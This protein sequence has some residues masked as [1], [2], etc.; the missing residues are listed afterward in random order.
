MVGAQPY[1]ALLGERDLEDKEHHQGDGQDVEPSQA[2]WRSTDTV[3]RIHARR[4]VR[5]NHGPDGKRE[6]DDR[7]D[8]EDAPVDLGA[9]DTRRVPPGPLLSS[10][11]VTGGRNS[12]RRGPRECSGTP[13]SAA[14]HHRFGALIPGALLLLL[15]GHVVLPCSVDA[16]APYARQRI[17]EHLI[18]PKEPRPADLCIWLPS[19]PHRRLDARGSG[20][21]GTVTL[22]STGFPVDVGPRFFE[23]RR[24]H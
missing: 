14:F 9:P 18:N 7:G 8:Y 6:D 12:W 21:R 15:I 22:I 20:R 1:T 5:Y 10:V 16:Y 4:T 23:A 11:L 17:Q 19:R 3:V 2:R 13:S 24:L